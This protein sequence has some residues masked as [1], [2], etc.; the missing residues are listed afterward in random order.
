[1]KI[2]TFSIVIFLTQLS[3]AQQKSTLIN[4]WNTVKSEII[5][6]AQYAPDYGATLTLI[7][8]GKEYDRLELGYADI[9]AKKKF[10]KKTIHQWASVSKIITS[11]AI[12]QLIEQGKIKLSDKITQYIPEL[13]QASKNEAFTQVQIHHLINHSS[14][15]YFDKLY[16]AFIKDYPRNK[17]INTH[18]FKDLMPYRNLIAFK[19]KPGKRFNYSNWGYSL[20][21]IV[22]ERVSKIR[23]IDYVQ[24]KI[25]LPLEMTNAYFGAST[26][27]EHVRNLSSCHLVQKDGNIIT[28]KQTF[29]Q[30]FEEAN[31][32]LK[33]TVNDMIQLMNFITY[34]GNKEQKKNYVKVLKEQT[35]KQY[36][37]VPSNSLTN[38]KNDSKKVFLAIDNAYLSS[39][40]LFGLNLLKYKTNETY[41]LGHSGHQ[42]HYISDIEWNIKENFGVILTI[43]TEGEKGTIP[44]Y[45][46]NMLLYY[47]TMLNMSQVQPIRVRDWSKFLK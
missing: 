25:L 13:K 21:G 7:I 5:K 46:Q 14:H 36:Y 20:L 2:I 15:V 38:E 42:Y 43:N 30:C 19:G 29:D 24:Q 8:N 12:L 1:M 47:V 9:T 3:F 34:K 32:G 10:S 27:K 18:C 40:R 16:E 37:G 4:A 35:L 44:Y 11:I 39:I 26:K 41:L 33:A 31:G 23:Y 45:F 22:I 28:E 6:N 17:K